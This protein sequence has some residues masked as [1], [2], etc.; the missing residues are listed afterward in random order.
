MTMWEAGSPENFIPIYPNRRCHIPE[1]NNLMNMRNILVFKDKL[2]MLTYQLYTVICYT[3]GLRMTLT[4]TSNKFS[5]P[6]NSPQRRHSAFSILKFTVRRIH[7]TA[8][9]HIV[10]E[11]DYLLGNVSLS[12]FM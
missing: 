6:S 10:M 8:A 1:K 5:E 3:F 9:Y 7:I 2:L 4:P 11:Y 12:T